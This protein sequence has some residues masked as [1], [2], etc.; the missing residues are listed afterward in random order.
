M[1]V[2]RSS[3]APF[4][5]WHGGAPEG[6]FIRNQRTAPGDF[7]ADGTFLENIGSAFIIERTT[8]MIKLGNVSAD[9]FMPADGIRLLRI[10]RPG[11]AET[12]VRA[13]I[14]RRISGR[15]PRARIRATLWDTNSDDVLGRGVRHAGDGA[16]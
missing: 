4:T 9:G 3:A 6:N 8:L 13:A 12:V 5:V 1:A 16:G 14:Q 7:V 10:R 2:C 11:N 15:S